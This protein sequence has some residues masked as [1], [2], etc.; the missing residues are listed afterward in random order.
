M[1]VETGEFAKARGPA[2]L[3]VLVPPT[4]FLPGKARADNWG[5]TLISTG[6]LACAHL[7]LYTGTHTTHTNKSHYAPDTTHTHTHTHTHTCPVGSH[8]YTHTH[9]HTHAHG[10]GKAAY[11]QTLWLLFQ[12]TLVWFPTS[13][14]G[15]QLSVT[16]VPRESDDLFW[17][18]WTQHTSVQ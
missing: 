16:L 4:R 8:T 3:E 10:P 15:S 12:R 13:R 7:L 6:T 9:T 5:C 2:S 11:V 17:P 14:C 1:G 18:M